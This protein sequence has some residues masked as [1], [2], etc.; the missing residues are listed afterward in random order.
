[1]NKI[2]YIRFMLNTSLEVKYKKMVC[3]HKVKT[4]KRNVRNRK[5]KNKIGEYIGSS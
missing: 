4:L 1:M 2:L 3:L 5:N